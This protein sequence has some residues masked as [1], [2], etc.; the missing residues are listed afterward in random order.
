MLTTAIGYRTIFY[1]NSFT[2]CVFLFLIANSCKNGEKKEL[3]TTGKNSDRVVPVTILPWH[4]QMATG[5]AARPPATMFY[6][7]PLR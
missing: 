1:T 5:K 4:L 7:M 6:A 3:S 2:L